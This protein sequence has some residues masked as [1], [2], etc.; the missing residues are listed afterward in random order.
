MPHLANLAAEGFWIWPFHEVRTP[1]AIEIY[2]RLLTRSVNKSDFSK[3]RAHLA[4]E[5]SPEI[6]GGLAC[7]A[8]SSEDAFDAAVSAVVMSRHIDEIAT[9]TR[10]QDRVELIE[11]AIWWPQD[12]RAAA[13]TSRPMPQSQTE[14]LFCDI[15]RDAVI[16]ELG[17]ALA[18][19]DR[20]PVSCGHTLVL[21]RAHVKSLFGLDAEAQADIWRLVARVRDELQSRLKPDGF[22][23]GIND[24]PAA[25]Q[26]VNHAHIHVIPRFD[27]DVVDP[28]G[29]IRW[30]LPDRAAYWDQ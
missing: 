13:T 8:A 9:L 12:T 15:S 6:G 25:G 5:C 18:I 1:M 29:G 19:Q 2:P 30:I 20:Y 14:C 26:T 11:G 24:G 10:S 3:R 17:H 4:A 22:N 27:G 23:I 28:R 21:P 7:K 16:D